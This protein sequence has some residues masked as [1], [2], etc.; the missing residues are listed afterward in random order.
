MPFGEFRRVDAVVPSTH[1]H[2]MQD[3][4]LEPVA[5]PEAMTR[6]LGIFQSVLGGQCSPSTSLTVSGAMQASHS[7]VQ[8]IMA[9]REQLAAEMAEA[10]LPLMAGPELAARRQLREETR[11]SVSAELKVAALRASR[12]ARERSERQRP[13]SPVEELARS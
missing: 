6:V 5:T 4:S 10:R 1:Q 13:S 8:S 11:K 2:R 9:T 12:E 3:H 7:A